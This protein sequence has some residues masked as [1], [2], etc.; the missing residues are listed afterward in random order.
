MPL[1]T[2]SIPNLIG[3][4]NQQPAAIRSINDAEAIDNAIPSPVEGLTKRPPTEHI[5]MLNGPSSAIEI[6]PAQPPFVHMIERDENERYI[7]TIQQNGTDIN[8]YDTA[9]VRK[10]FYDKTAGGVGCGSASST[11]RKALT[12]GDVTFIVNTNTAVAL[13][14]ATT[15]Q[16]PADYTKAAMV[17]IKQSGSERRSTINLKTG[18]TSLSISHKPTSSNFGTDHVAGQLA[19]DQNAGSGGNINDDA[20][21]IASSNDSV[22]HITS[23]T[24]AS[25]SI[26]VE[27]DYGGDGL[28]LIRDEIARFE[29]LP[30]TAVHN[31]MVKVLGSTEDG[32]DDYWVKFRA[33]DEVFS[34][35]VWEECAAPGIKY[36]L[37]ATTMPLI[38]IRQSDGSF[39]LKT[40]DGT[41]PAT[42]VPAGASYADYKW[43]ERLVGDEDTN[44]EPSF[45]GLKILDM[46]YH[47]SRFG[48]LAGENI[49]FTE[50]SEFFNF[51]RN[52]ALDL[53]DTDSIDLASSNPRVG[54]VLAAIPFNRDLIVFTPTNQLILRSGDVLSPKSVALLPCSDFES[55]VNIVK[56]VPSANSIFFTYTNGTFVGLRELIPQPAL[57]GAYYAND[58]TDNVSTYIPGPPSH[59]AATTHENIAIVVSQG[60]IYGYRYFM[61]GNDRVQSAWFR[62]TFNSSHPSTSAYAKPIW[63]GFIESD[64]YVVFLRN[65]LSAAGGTPVAHQTLEKIRMG[66]GANDSAISGKTWLTY[67]D[68]R[69]YYA[70]GQ[71]TY[72]VNLNRTTFTLP[73]PMRYAAGKTVAVT[74][75]GYQPLVL[76]GTAPT[77]PNTDAVVYVQGNYSAAPL[78]IGTPYTMEYE[79]STPYLRTNVGKGVAAM[80]AGRYQLRYMTIQFSNSAYFKAQVSIKNES[81]YEYVFT[82]ETVGTAVIGNTNISSGSFR[83]PIHSKNDNTTIKLINDSPLPSKFLS[84]EI[85]AF[86]NDRAVRA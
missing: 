42:N 58:L 59:I 24:N 53:L 29:D 79:F 51:W 34:R 45:V 15:T 84:C 7:L 17:W 25:F 78:W 70:S 13:D 18:A 60:N 77:N 37:N 55:Q 75:D 49:V 28:I 31:W 44:P 46:V 80:L 9:G 69:K 23:Q 21:Y 82:G 61:Q 36:K 76:G 68:Q 33:N 74:V 40:A 32:T 20:N 3:G 14:N 6:D 66:V 12:I 85:E 86:Y 71:G 1:I 50:T 2:T 4:V 48:I 72:D 11:Q 62:F 41:T 35:G 43:G 54:K 65:G 30:P 64:L 8:I 73:R 57:D 56:P 67:L 39:L 27:D 22:I 83:V 47:Q 52:T 26:D 63:A 19:T 81:T 16:T 5:A 38:L 10:T